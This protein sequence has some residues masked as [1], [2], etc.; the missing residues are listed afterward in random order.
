MK[1]RIITLILI[2]A[3]ILINSLN[4]VSLGQSKK[5]PIEPQTTKAINQYKDVIRIYNYARLVRDM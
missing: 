1:L 4:A 3:F 5:Y 2:S